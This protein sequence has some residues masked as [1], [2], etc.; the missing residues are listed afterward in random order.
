MAAVAGA[1]GEIGCCA[2]CGWRFYGFKL[3]LTTT[4]E[5]LPNQA[6]LIPAASD[7]LE[8]A[9]ALLQSGMI[10]IGDHSFSRFASL[11]WRHT[12]D[13][14]GVVVLAPPPR[15]RAANH[16]PAKRA[17]LAYVRNRIETVIGLLKR[18]HGL[19]HHEARS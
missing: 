5:M 12:L 2:A 13:H 8:A 18:K 7:K 16:H 4:V 14:A 3:V 15:R 10:L 11:A 17:F 19:E 1:R 9:T 6:V